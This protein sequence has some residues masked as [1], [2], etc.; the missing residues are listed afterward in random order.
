MFPSIL[1]FAQHRFNSPLATPLVGAAL[2]L[3]VVLNKTTC[4]TAHHPITG[5]LPL[6]E[7][8]SVTYSIDTL[9]VSR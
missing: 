5:Q 3:Y 7:R 8:Q 9:W 6:T 4:L 2:E 1:I